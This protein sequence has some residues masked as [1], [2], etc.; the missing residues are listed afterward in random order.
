MVTYATN[1]LMASFEND[2]YYKVVFAGHDL[3]SHTFPYYKVLPYLMIL[4]STYTLQFK[5]HIRVDFR[6]NCYKSVAIKI[7]YVTSKFWLIWL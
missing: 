2:H 5:Y 7:M 4:I 6:V 3:G 1:G